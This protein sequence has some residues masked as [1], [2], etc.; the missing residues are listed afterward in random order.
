MFVRRGVNPLNSVCKLFSGIVS[1]PLFQ[2]VG[3][4]RYMT[5]QTIVETPP[6]VV[7]HARF[8]VLHPYAFANP[9]YG[10]SSLLDNPA[11][12]CLRCVGS[13][14]FPYWDRLLALLSTK[15]MNLSHLSVEFNILA[16][17]ISNLGHFSMS[18]QILACTLT[19]V[20]IDV[21]GCHTG[22]DAALMTIRL[23][24]ENLISIHLLNLDRGSSKHALVKHGWA[25]R[26]KLRTLRLSRCYLAFFLLSDFIYYADAIVNLTLEDCTPWDSSEGVAW[27][28]LPKSR[29]FDRL[30]IPNSYGPSPGPEAGVIVVVRTDRRSDSESTVTEMP[31]F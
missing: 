8:L 23:H 15:P 12:S 19:S 5:S 25:C 7:Q 17:G 31:H 24:L 3:V 16:F 29:N 14:S 9:E 18:M 1:R 20:T 2:V 22:H 6:N 4:G 13:Q 21:R 26:S 30:D 28:D 10:W 27:L 11:L